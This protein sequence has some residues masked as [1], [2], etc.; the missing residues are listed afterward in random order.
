MDFKIR[1]FKTETND[2]VIYFT[3]KYGDA[4]HFFTTPIGGLYEPASMY[5]SKQKMIKSE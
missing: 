2:A 5:K 3:N 1:K 4:V